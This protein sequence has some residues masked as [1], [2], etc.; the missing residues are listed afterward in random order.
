MASLGGT[1]ERQSSADALPPVTA[2]NPYLLAHSTLV[3]FANEKLDS[4]A[5]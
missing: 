3:P 4:S 1:E 2:S 5:L